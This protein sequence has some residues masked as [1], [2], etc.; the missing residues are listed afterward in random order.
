MQLSQQ[1]F[2]YHTNKI[3]CVHVHVSVVSGVDGILLKYA[4]LSPYEVV[5]VKPVIAYR[6]DQEE[7]VHMTILKIT[8]PA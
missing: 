7:L 4:T 6:P 3:N 1:M 8:I 5:M 2:T